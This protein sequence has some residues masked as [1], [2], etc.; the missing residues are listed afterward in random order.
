MAR[1]EEPANLAQRLA[2]TRALTLSLKAHPVSFMR[3]VF[4]R[5]G[6]VTTQAL[7]ET[8]PGRRVTAA[9]SSDK[10]LEFSSGKLKC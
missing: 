10:V 2:A 4:A 7:L 1:S 3:E 9:P 8:R 6:V 5:A